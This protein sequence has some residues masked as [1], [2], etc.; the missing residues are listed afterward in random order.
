MKIKFKDNE[1]QSRFETYVCKNR[2]GI[3]YF[4]SV[5]EVVK[6][7]PIKWALRMAKKYVE[8]MQC[9][10]SFSTEDIGGGGL[11]PPPNP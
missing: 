1:Q 11:P 4:L 2:Q 7:T 9:P 6:S 5:G 8:S 3:L 10:E